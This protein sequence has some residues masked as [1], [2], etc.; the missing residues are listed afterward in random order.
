MIKAASVTNGGAYTITSNG[1][2]QTTI[3]VGDGCGG[4][5]AG[6]SILLDV[7]GGY[8]NAV[9]IQAK[10]GTG[11]SQNN[12]TCHGAGGGGGGGVIWFSQSSA[13][14]NV[15]TSVTG[16]A[17][18]LQTAASPDCGDVNW[19]ATAGSAGGVLY[20]TSSG[21]SYFLNMNSCNTT[22][23]VEL[24]SF[25]GEVTETGVWLNWTTA[26]EINSDHYSI[27]RTEDLMTYTTIGSL[28]AAGNSSTNNEYTFRDE[29][30]PV[31]ELYYRLKQVDFDGKVHYPGRVIR[32]NN[33]NP[34]LVPVV[35]PN[36][37]DGRQFTVNLS[38][39]DQDEVLV[40]IVNDMGTIVWEQ[41]VDLKSGDNKLVSINTGQNLTAGI[42][43]V[44]VTSLAGQQ[45]RR[46]I[47]ARKE[48]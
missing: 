22:L 24:V 38:S 28:S 46:F 47:V 16:G 34:G 6:G 19:G 2:S 14:A 37:N 35:S 30:A 7:S 26:S 40:R 20:G 21:A 17:N 4:G 31:K 29:H 3:A 10:G 11:G 8:T 9:T 13:P 18:G 12:S 41:F 42:Y 44:R 33:V 25:T 23:P 45:T 39:Y 48:E 5:G 15:T 27:E 1:A 43:T 36:P 32:V